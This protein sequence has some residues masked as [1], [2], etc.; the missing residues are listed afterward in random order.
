MAITALSPN[1]SYSPGADLWVL[2]ELSLSK[3]AQKLDWYLNFQ[4][5]KSQQRQTLEISPKIQQILSKTGLSNHDFIES[6]SERLL[7]ASEKLLPNRW[8][9][10][11]T[12][13]NDFSKWV[14]D[15]YQSWKGLRQPQM[16]VFLPSG[17][18]E[19]EFRAA[20]QELDNFEEV[21]IVLE[22]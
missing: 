18:T 6:H 5:Q 4:I 15:I 11:V 3:N 2:P 12:G 20:W 13:A 21:A 22:S 1:A 9:I 16:R 14:K 17:K 19:R 7:I 8:V 10:V